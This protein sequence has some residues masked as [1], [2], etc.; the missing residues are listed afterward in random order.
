MYELFFEASDTPA[1]SYAI[2][3]QKTLGT[4]VWGSDY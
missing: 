2:G 1:P 4:E 3:W